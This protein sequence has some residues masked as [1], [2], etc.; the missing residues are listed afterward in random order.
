MIIKAI[1]AE[2]TWPL[3][4]AVLWPQ[5]PADFVKLPEDPNGYHFGLF[6]DNELVSVVSLF[7][8]AVGMA[9]FRKFATLSDQQGKGYGAKLLSY[10]IEFAQK[11][12]F[13]TLWCNARA[14]KLGFYKK[15]GMVET[16]E[17][18]TKE[19]IKF[20]ILKKVL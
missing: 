13:R 8:T 5:M 10:L 12:G 15:F 4:H 7:S 6:L 11:K 20:A 9:Q 19:N 18:F 1:S 16:Q 3:R 2:E 17:G 14:D